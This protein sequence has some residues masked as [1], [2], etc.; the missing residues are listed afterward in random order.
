MKQV[1]QIINEYLWKECIQLCKYFL[2]LKKVSNF[3]MWEKNA[4]YGINFA[5]IEKSEES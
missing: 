3:F 4:K 5:P 2:H 1:Q